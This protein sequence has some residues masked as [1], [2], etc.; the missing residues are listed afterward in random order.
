[1]SH[2]C[3]DLLAWNFPQTR[4]CPVSLCQQSWKE[5]GLDMP[6]INHKVAIF[7]HFQKFLFIISFV[8]LF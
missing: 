1:M 6:Y 4:C 3:N 5:H 2:L 8:F 7:L